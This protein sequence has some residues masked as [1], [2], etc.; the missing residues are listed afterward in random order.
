[1][2]Y[3]R[4]WLFG[5]PIML[6]VLCVAAASIPVEPQEPQSDRPAP[7]LVRGAGSEALHSETQPR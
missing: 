2:N 6:F 5:T 4:V 7:A 3:Q 1:M